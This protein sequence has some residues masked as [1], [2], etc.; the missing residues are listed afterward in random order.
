M[1]GAGASHPAGIP[2]IMDLTENFLNDPLQIEY[3]GRVGG[4]G[5]AGRDP[6]GIGEKIKTLSEITQEHF[7]KMDLETMMSLIVQLESDRLGKLL[8]TQFPSLKSIEPAKLS[9]IKYLIQDYIR[10]KCEKIKTVEYFAPLQG[11]KP[12]S[13]SLNIFTLNYDGTIEIFCEKNNIRCADGFDPYWNPSNFNDNKDGVNLFKLHGSLYW[14][15][16]E[17][18]KYIKVPIKGL[19]ITDM[20]YLTDESVSEM[21]IYPELEKDK[22]SVV[23]SSLSQKFKEELNHTEVCVIIG[24]SFRDD[25]IRN[26]IIE[27]LSTNPNLWLVL[28]SPHASKHKKNLFSNND[29]I[30]SKIVVIDVT[31]EEILSEGKLFS[32][33]STL[34]NARTTEENTVISQ[35]K[36]ENRLDLAWT[37]ILANYLAIGHHDRIKW[38]TERLLKV[39]FS[40]ISGNFPR[41]IEATLCPKSIRYLIEYYQNDKKEKLQT[42]KKFFVDACIHLEYAFFQNNVQLRNNNPIK[43]N[44]IPNNVKSFEYV[45]ENILNEL[46]E[47]AEDILAS[48]S[49]GALKTPLNKLIQTCDLLTHKEYT[50]EEHTGYHSITAAEIL[51]GY[52]NNDLGIK[53]WAT[54][55]VNSL[56]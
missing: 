42:W 7:G 52:R 27:S 38:I 46:K 1:F 40:G 56:K 48:T 39:K 6:E 31:T 49:N 32:Y 45:P 20:R 14:F 25:D 47:E 12:K 50:N 44:E 33:L 19:R 29:E 53:K 28:V 2:T 23:Y 36:S 22:Q 37:N 21:M 18:G 30:A 34:E 10:K 43:L 17:S 26:N 24:Y 51:E 4:F 11:L 54:E 5:G 9:R 16:S 15:K 41:T 8:V 35:H 55:I 13:E 3:E